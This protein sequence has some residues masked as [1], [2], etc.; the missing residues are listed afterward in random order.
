MVTIIFAVPGIDIRISTHFHCTVVI[1]ILS[2]IIWHKIQLQEMQKRIRVPKEKPHL[3]VPTDH[4]T[5]SDTGY[6]SSRSSDW[7]STSSGLSSGYDSSRSSDWS[8]TSS[9]LSSGYGSSR[10]SDW[11]STSSGLSSGYGSSRSSDWSSTYSSTLS[12]DYLTPLSERLHTATI[13]EESSTAS[14]HSSATS[15]ST[16]AT[17]K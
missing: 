6:G 9:G 2:T 17:K 8:S 16:A 10:L 5:S 11:S 1:P 7:S 14:Y 13:L 4:Y 3:P 12:S 15:K